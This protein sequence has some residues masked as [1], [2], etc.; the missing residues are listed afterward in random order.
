MDY[1]NDP[2]L[3]G[4]YLGTITKDF[5]TVSDTLKEASYQIRKREISK[6]PIF[7]F[8]RQE[9]PL[10]GLLVN[11]DE[12]NLEWHVFASYL[13]VFVQQRVISPEGIEAFE[14]TYKDPEEYCCLFVLDEEF[15]NFVYVPYPED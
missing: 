14:Q 6:Y 1:S 9:V 4:K 7:V 12:L 8:A 10:G 3:N 11:A 13:D 5:A 15:T 2:E